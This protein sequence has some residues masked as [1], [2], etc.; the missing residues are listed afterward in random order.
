MNHMVERKEVGMRVNESMSVSLNESVGM[1]GLL[2][3]LISEL[4]MRYVRRDALHVILITMCLT[5]L[6]FALLPFNHGLN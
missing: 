1:I 3:S 6:S 4:R 2:I 5:I